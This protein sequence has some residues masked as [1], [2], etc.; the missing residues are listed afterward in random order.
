MHFLMQCILL[1]GKRLSLLAF[2]T[3]LKTMELTTVFLLCVLLLDK[4]AFSKADL[5]DSAKAEEIKEFSEAILQRVLEEFKILREE[6]ASMRDTQHLMQTEIVELKE[7]LN[8]SLERRK[9]MEREN[10][11]LR[12][13]Y[14]SLIKQ[15]ENITLDKNSLNK[16]LGHIEMTKRT[17]S[18]T[19]GPSTTP[20]VAFYAVMNGNDITNIHTSQVF[21]Y[22][23]VHVNSLNAYNKQ[24]GKFTAPVKGIYVFF[25]NVL[26]FLGKKLEALIVRNDVNFCNIYAGDGTGYGSGSNMAVVALEVGDV[27][28]VKV[29]VHDSGV[30][31]DG[32][33]TSFSGFLLFDTSEHWIHVEP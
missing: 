17:L 20:P 28:W 24:N 13:E 7:K 6:V 16:R 23:Y 8:V 14:E 31:L 30:H 19:A 12:L 9:E 4:T 21:V 22:D 18:S 3:F 25:A 33:W 27:V 1:E 29:H 5:Q 11:K 32:P 2:Y 26:T 15:T 10:L